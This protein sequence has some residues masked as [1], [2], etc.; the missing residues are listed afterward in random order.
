MNGYDIAREDELHPGYLAELPTAEPLTDLVK[1]AYF[2]TAI[3]PRDT[4]K[5]EHQGGMGACQG[6]ALSSIV[7]W[8]YMLQTGDVDGVQLSR[9]AAYFETQRL[10]RI[11]GDRGSTISGGVKLARTW[12]VPDESLWRYPSRYDADRP[13]NWDAVTASAHTHKIANAVKV[14][15]YE[16]ARAF[17]GSNVGGISIGVRW[18][19]QYGAVIDRAHKGK[20]GHAVALISLSKRKDKDGLPYLWLLNSWGTRW[21]N[22]GWAEVSPAALRSWLRDS[23]TTAV[24]LT[25][26]PNIQPRDFDLETWAGRLSV[27]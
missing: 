17:L 12:G 21:G 2:E 1:F 16:Q 4:I 7:E 3:D 9:A 20:G 13:D 8:C 27:I 11:R 24:G 22:R 5:I 15:D 6:H 10:D 18:S 26:M 25:E 19:R 23:F 14:T